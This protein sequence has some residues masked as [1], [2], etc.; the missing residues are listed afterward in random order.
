MPFIDTLTWPDELQVDK[1]V[2]EKR[3]SVKEF[4]SSVVY[5]NEYADFMVWIRALPNDAATLLISEGL[6]VDYM[7]C[8]KINGAAPSS[9]LSR[10]SRI[11]KVVKICRSI[12]I[13]GY[14]ELWSTLKRWN[15]QLMFYYIYI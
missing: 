10:F 15:K 5:W 12:D 6:C 13:S 7:H 3:H 11:K 14:Q 8:L 4:A 2:W 1:M 9:L